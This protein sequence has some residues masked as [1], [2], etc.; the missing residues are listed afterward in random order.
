MAKHF[1]PHLYQFEA[2]HAVLK[3]FY[4]CLF[5]DPGLGKTAIILRAYLTLKKAG[6]V[7]AILVIAP[8]RPVY[9][10]WPKE[11]KK[12]IFS[13][14]LKVEILHG[15]DKHNAL[16]RKA[17]IYVINPE[18]LRWLFKVGLRNKRNWPFDMLVVD[19]SG[20]FRN[21]DSKRLALLKPKLRKF[22]RRYTLNGTPAPKSLL[23]LWAQ[24]L[25]ADRGKTFGS[26]I[27]HYRT[28]YF[29][30]SGYM[31]KEWIIKSDEHRERIYKRAQRIALV[32]EAKDH[33]KGMPPITYNPIYVELPPD[34]QRYY[35]EI[36]D[37]LFTVIEGVE[38]ELSNK[39]VSQMATRQIAA[40]ALYKPAPEGVKPP[41]G[42]MRE[43][44]TLHDQKVEALIELSEE[45]QGKPLIVA[46]DFHHSLVKAREGIKK[47]FK[48]KKLPPYIGRGVSGTEGERLEKQW[49]NGELQWLFTNTQSCAYGLNLQGGPGVDQFWY[50]PTYN[51][52][53]YVQLVKRLWRQ[54][55][56]GAVRIHHCIALNT[57]DEAMYARQGERAEE[58]QRLI[59]AL[60]EYRYR[61]LNRRRKAA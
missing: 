22:K 5:L 54:G 49:H 55:A 26:K 9:Q 8:M 24:Y 30:K 45:L 10:V 11:V 33:L 37:D 12:W 43:W 32:M 36:E 50:D 4:H 15:S 20:R 23:D 31:D 7:K 58:Q 56:L 19:E 39:A 13:K 25:L 59:D 57:V 1:L 28:T 41:P 6:K 3:Y 46:Y 61:K 48:L 17:D 52:E 44:H 60:K 2:I 18:G 34:V 38:H 51:L 40:G 53:W 16:W 14:G 35:E 29:K 47:A 21:P 27:G 42:Y